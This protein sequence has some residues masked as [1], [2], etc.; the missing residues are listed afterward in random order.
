MELR[1]I[2]IVIWRSIGCVFVI[3]GVATAI[4]Q[5]GVVTGTF[6]QI[7]DSESLYTGST[8]FAMFLWP[9]VLS[10]TGLIMFLASR[11]LAGVVVHRIENPRS[12]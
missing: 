12:Q 10:T 11:G 6:G 9:I 8:L 5:F 2:A 1:S 4:V 3:Y 7:M